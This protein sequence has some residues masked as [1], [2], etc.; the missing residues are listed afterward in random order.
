MQWFQFSLRTKVI[1]SLTFLMASA[2]LLIAMVMLKVNQRDL[3][4][5]K[6]EQG[7]VLKV[8]LERLLNTPFGSA[9]TKLEL[10]KS[11]SLLADFQAGD[12]DILGAWQVTVADRSGRVVYASH[13][14][15]PGKHPHL[16]G[17]EQVMR[18]GEEKIS[19]KP[20]Q[21]SFWRQL[22]EVIVLDA[23]LFRNS[24]IIGGVRLEAELADVRQSLWQSQKLLLF[25][26]FL[27]VF[28][29]VAFGTYIF[30]KLVVKPVKQLVQT[31]ERFQ[32]GDRLP[33]V[34][35]GEMN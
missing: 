4:Q 14:N 7:L 18:F 34:G 20:T 25:Y 11:R 28:V 5:A 24:N 16:S 17:L 30:S 33:D 8:S 19:F 6:V 1:L 27:D 32:E 26:I 2:M 15:R 12:P 31:A 29:L 13:G 35:A 23:P 22:P 10:V 9:G 3:V 21:K